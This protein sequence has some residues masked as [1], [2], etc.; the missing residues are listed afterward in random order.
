MADWSFADRGFSLFPLKPLSKIPLGK[1]KTYMGRHATP[2]ELAVWRSRSSHNSGVATG[3]ISGV[4]VVDCDNLEARLAVDFKGVPDTLTIRTPRGTHM[5]FQ[6]PGWPIGN[7][8]GLMW[9]GWQDLGVDIRGDGGFVVG[10]GSTY[11]PTTA[12]IAKGKQPGSYSV[13]CDLPLAPLP[14][15]LLEMLRPKPSS[16]P[17]VAVSHAEV[18]SAYGRKCL[19]EKLADLRDCGSGALSHQIY[20]TT[21]RIAEL[22]AGGEITQEDGWDGLHDVL[23]EKG[24]LDE[25]K[26]NGTV[27]RAWAKGFEEPKAAPERDD[28]PRPPLDAMAVLGARQ[29][30]QPLPVGVVPPVPKEGAAL[31]L[32]GPGDTC[33]ILHLSN[34]DLEDKQNHLAVEYWMAMKGMTVSY[35]AF[36]DRV[37]LNGKTLTD[38]SERKAWFDVREQSTVKFSKELFG[39]VVRNIAHANTFHPLCDWLEA[40]EA[41]WDGVERL[42]NWLT[43]YLGVAPSPYVAAVGAIFLTAAVQRARQ[44]GCKYDELLVL[45][46]PQGINKSSAMAALCPLQEWFSEDFTVSMNSKELLEATQG[47]WIVEA[48]ELSKLKGS[49][50]EHVKHLLSRRFDRARLA[51][52][53]NA[54]ERGR[55]WVGVATVNAD[56]YLSDPS[57]N[58]RFWPVKCG[59]ID[60]AG[61]KRDHAQLWAEAAIRERAGGIT[62]LPSDLWG[63]A[64]DEQRERVT[65]DPFTEVLVQTLG[66]YENGRISTDEVWD[67][68][69]VPIDRRSSQGLRLGEAMKNLGWT[70]RRAKSKGR[71]FYAYHKG[72][73]TPE[74]GFNERSGR[75]EILPPELASI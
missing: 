64:A 29:S 18:T 14:A 10:P 36:A 55:Q 41:E 11:E 21:V 23:A 24:L 62:R 49:E 70:R 68:V 9:D 26:A 44:P 58:R 53:R 40:N 16:A 75:Y 34:D 74:I 63:A 56:T 20:K 12:E 1:W 35:D 19:E 66:H 45:E 32:T 69:K 47:K 59:K 25:D 67:I 65:V 48:P 7:K 15:W 33:R 71:N 31:N 30:A 42:D 8:V 54:T 37:L 51:Y 43:I 3:A 17:V 57:G 50:V 73:E 39:E 46:G 38:D 27:Q 5:Y 61:I 2:E 28:V 72:T 13:E 22:V 6:H 52:G 60:L 4:I